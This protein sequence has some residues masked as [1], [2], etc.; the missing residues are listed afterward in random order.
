MGKLA[1]NQAS[2]KEYAYKNLPGLVK[3][4]PYQDIYKLK[5]LVKNSRGL[6]FPSFYEGFGLPVIEAFSQGIPVLH[7]NTS[8]LPEIAASLGISCDPYDLKS[9]EQGLLEMIF[10]NN[11]KEIVF[12]R[13]QWAGQF[14][15]ALAAQKFSSVID[16]V[17]TDLR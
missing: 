8:C 1:A 11:E 5:Y 16:G 4:I 7:S 17:M 9:I 13:K 3:I 6:L 12:K 14:T 10:L 2:I 15:Y